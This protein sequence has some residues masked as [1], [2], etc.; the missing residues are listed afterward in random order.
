MQFSDTVKSITRE[1]IVP[2]VYDTVLNG[3]VGLLRLWGNARPWK[4]GFRYDVPIKFSKATT[5]GLVGL[6]GTLDTTRQTNRVK[7]Q[8]DPKRRHKPV[9]LDDIETQVN[10]GDERVLEL[11]ATEMD[12][13]GQDL[14]DDSGTDFYTGTGAG[15]N[16]DSLYNAADDATNFATYGGLAKATYT[17]IKGYLSASVG[18]LAL[19]DLSTAHSSVKRGQDKP[20]L[21]LAD[22]TSWTAYEGLLQPTVRAGYEASGFPQVTRTGTV[23]SQ[24]ALQGDIGF[25]S[26]WYRGTPVVEDEKCPSGNIFLLHENYFYFAGIDIDD[27]EKFNITSSNVDGPQSAPVPRGFNWSGLLR[28]PSQPAE[29]GHLYVIGNYIGVDPRRTGSLTG[30]TG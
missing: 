14:L 3:N 30:I 24:R 20:T 18:A 1:T 13:I 9:V 10:K 27:Y 8:F 29:V 5:G 6:G 15:E 23:P 19:P 16:F 28:S 17:S 4:S 7:L 26:I 2:K 11:L 12:S 22:T 25:D 21:M